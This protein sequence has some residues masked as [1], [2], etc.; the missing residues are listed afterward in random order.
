MDSASGSMAAAR[1]RKKVGESWWMCGCVVGREEEGKRWEVKE[2]RRDLAADILCGL[3]CLL[4][5]V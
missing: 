1:G 2:A 5:E 4:R 3:R